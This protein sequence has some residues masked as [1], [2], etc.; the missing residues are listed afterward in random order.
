MAEGDEVKKPI[1]WAA[2]PQA[3]KKLQGGWEPPKPAPFDCPKMR[4]A[5]KAVESAHGKAAADKLFSELGAPASE[6][7]VEAPF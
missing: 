4:R 1:M 3:K 7:A 2:T 6:D 5:R